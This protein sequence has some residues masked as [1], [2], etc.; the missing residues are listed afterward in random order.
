M[1]FFS[2]LFKPAWNNDDWKK[3]Q[4]AV[5]RVTDQNELELIA[6]EANS[7]L[8]R[9]IAVKKIG[10]KRVLEEIFKNYKEDEEV[11]LAAAYKLTSQEAYIYILTGDK[12]SSYS[13]I[14]A[15]RKITDL[16]T[17]FKIANDSNYSPEIREA[18][19]RRLKEITDVYIVKCSECNGTGGSTDYERFIGK[20]FKKCPKCKG[21]KE[22]VMTKMEMMEN[23]TNEARKKSM[24]TMKLL[25]IPH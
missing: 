8:V 13:R 17:L 9:K 3:A 10:N 22:F 20:T 19:I 7:F 24:E 15:I 1:G 4:R 21:K 23:R 16:N 6:K 18:A 25:G 11:R 14:D 2:N 5:E 12:A